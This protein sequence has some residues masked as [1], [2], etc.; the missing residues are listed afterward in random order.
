MLGYDR[1]RINPHTRVPALEIVDEAANLS[2]RRMRV[3][4][5]FAAGPA[6]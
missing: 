5:R 4:P 3:F 2:Q 6:R 1:R